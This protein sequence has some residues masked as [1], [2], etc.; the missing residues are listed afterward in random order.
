METDLSVASM[1]ARELIVS[2][3]KAE[4]EFPESTKR[5]AIS[6]ALN[7]WRRYKKYSNAPDQVQAFRDALVLEIRALERKVTQYTI[8][9]FLNLDPPSGFES[10]IVR[11]H[12]LQFRAW[13]ELSDLDTSDLWKKTWVYDRENPIILTH[14]D[15]KAYPRM[16]DFAPVILKLETYDVQAAVDIASERLDLLRA[17]LNLL[18]AMRVM[19]R[20]GEPEP[21]SKLLPSPI[22]GVFDRNG[23]LLNPYFTIERYDKYKYRKQRIE[24]RDYKTVTELLQTMNQAQEGSISHLVLRL[25]QLY[26]Q[27]LDLTDSRATYLALWQVLEAAILGHERGEGK[28]DSRIKALIKPDDLMDAVVTSLAKHRHLLVHSGVFPNEAESLVFVLKGIVDFEPRFRP[29]GHCGLHHS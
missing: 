25:L 4:P 3:V 2:S 13:S 9:M 28:M 5:Q 20:W 18:P 17:V 6:L 10:L 1:A 15:E 24:E 22:Y 27:A 21:L 14:H 19:F 16:I 7:R 29:E 23:I 8:L 12:T 26:Q 11:K